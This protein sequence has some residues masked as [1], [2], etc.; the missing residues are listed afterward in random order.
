MKLVERGIVVSFHARCTADGKYAG[1]VTSAKLVNEAE[2]ISD[3][4]S[5]RGTVPSTSRYDKPV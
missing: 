5:D 2:P 3:L 1:L 4:T